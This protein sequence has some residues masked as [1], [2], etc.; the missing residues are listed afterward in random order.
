MDVAETIRVEDVEPFAGNATLVE[1][2]ETIGPLG[3]TEAVSATIPVKPLRLVK[4][5]VA[6]PDDP[7]ATVSMVGFDVALKSGPVVVLECTT[8]LPIMCCRCIEQ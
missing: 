8:R 7:W 5:M 4:V 1:L 2:N 3:E 6:D